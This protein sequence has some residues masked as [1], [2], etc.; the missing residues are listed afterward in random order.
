MMNVWYLSIFVLLVELPG[1]L[2]LL[3]TKGVIPEHREIDTQFCFGAKT[4][5]K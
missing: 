2:I 3:F 1:E 4:Q 5:T